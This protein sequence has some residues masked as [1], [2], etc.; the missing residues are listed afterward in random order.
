M[1]TQAGIWID[2]TQAVV[3]LITNKGPEFK[4]VTSDIERSDRASDIYSNR[5]RRSD[6]VAEDRLERKLTANLRKFYDE[7][8]A[9]VSGAKEV[10]LLGPGEA[11]G[12]FV[13]HIKR[14]KLKSPVIE[15]ETSDK[16]TERQIV[17]KVKKHFATVP[18]KKS[19]PSKKTAFEKSVKEKSTK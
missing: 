9:S 18:V 7:V 13:N 14:K 3:V 17:V 12:E 15:Q 5:Y 19:I 11:K 4:K 8:I 2:H 1:G 16:M 6:Y 10:L